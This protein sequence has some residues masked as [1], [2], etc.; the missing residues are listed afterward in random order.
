MRSLILLVALWGS[1]FALH[2]ATPKDT[3]VVAVP[4]DGIISFDPAESFETV[5]NS[6]QHNIYQTLVEADRNDPQKLA[7]LLATH[8]Q[9]GSTP[10]SLVFN[11]QPDAHFSSGN[12]VTAQ[13]VIFS[14]TRAV[15]LN[16][17]PSF[18]LAEFGWTNENIASQFK[19]LND[20][21][22]EIQWPAQIGQN[23]ALRLL[24]APVASVVDSKTVQQHVANNDLGNGWLHTNSAGSGAFIL[25]QYVPQQALVLSANQQANPQPKLKRILLKGVADA[26]ARRLL[27]QQGDV[28]VA[29]QL[30]PDQIDAL[31]SDKNLRIEAFPSSLVYYLGFNTKDKAQPAL[32]NPALWQAARWLVDYHSIS[33]DLLK[34]QY[35]I[36]QSF[37]PQGFDGAL[38]D[39]PFHYDVAKA[40]AI[41]A[42][43]GI[44]PGTKFALTVINQPPY[45]DVAQALQASFAKADMQIELQPVAE[46]ELWSKM[47]GRDFQS[48]FIYWG[49]DYVD[50]NTNASAFAYN[51]PGGSKTL[52][53]RVGWDIPD[54][55]AKTRAAAGESDAAKR[56]ALY[57]ELQKTVQQNSPFV[58]TLQGAQQVAVRNNVNHV[59]QGIGVSLLFFDSV[60]K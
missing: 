16:K 17:A 51:V 52:A 6:V 50:P 10:H 21:Q 43:G 40:K 9:Q 3:L 38:D 19:V 45:I 8:W 36:H 15:Q 25:Q 34:G 44:K 23:L 22:L 41:L 5:S 46:S 24:T 30:G 29:Y 32:G 26:G 4:L 48:I 1:S 11:I 60:Q 39:Q 2:A 31:K 59:Q 53:W 13:D 55:S 58:V 27:I 57:T 56:R 33:K 14:L 20:H 54:L 47:R 42:K 37:L 49:A 18:I 35:R 28:D 12:P 7:P